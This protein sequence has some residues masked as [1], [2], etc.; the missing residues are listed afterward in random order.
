MGKRAA[1]DSN[2]PAKKRFKNVSKLI[3]PNTSGIYATCPRRKESSCRQ[4]LMNLLS[5][6]IPEYFDLSKTN[7]DDEDEDDEKKELSIED[8][9]KL[10]LEELKDI[11]DSKKELLQP[12]ELDVECLIFIK[13]RKPI[14]PELLVH[15]I[16]KE[17]YETGQKTTRY[18]QRLMP[19]MD[20]CTIGGDEPLDKIRELAKKVLARHFHNEKDQ[21]P[22]KFAIQVSKR[23]FNQLQSDGIIKAV[24]EAVGQNHGHS[25]DLKTYEKLIIVECYKNSVGIG[26]ADDFLKFSRFN[27]QQIYEKQQDEKK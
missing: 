12:I 17:S 8:K 7:E 27:L 6:K 23:N 21:K 4:E 10:E 2:K 5:D 18:T 26:V 15:K 24:A 19:I 13:T 1:E 3:D 14:D 9:I 16:C 22:I 20:T 25:V 11:K